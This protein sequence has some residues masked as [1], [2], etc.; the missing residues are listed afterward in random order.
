MNKLYGMSDI[1]QHYLFDKCWGQEGRGRVSIFFKYLLK[2]CLNNT[3][4]LKQNPENFS[5][6]T[7]IKFSS[8]KTLSFKTRNK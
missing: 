4:R 7:I 8:F 6:R 3:L 5:E 2:V 1:P